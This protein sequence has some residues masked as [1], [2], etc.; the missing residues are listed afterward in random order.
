MEIKWECPSTATTFATVP[1]AEAGGQSR[2]IF[3]LPGNPASALVTFYLFAL[4]SLRA[5]GGWPT[6]RRHLPR[7]GVEVRSLET[8]GRI[9]FDKRVNQIDCDMRL[10]AREEFHRVVISPARDRSGVL[11]A[12]S[13]GGQQSSRVASLCGANGLVHLPLSE[14][15]GKSK[16]HKGDIVNAVIIGEIRG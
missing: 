16:V 2:I 5:L 8:F 6:E 7:I 9:A 1:P 4:P 10:D 12:T 13:T 15:G 11:V 3:A 14:A